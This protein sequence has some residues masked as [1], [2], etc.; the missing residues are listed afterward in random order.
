[1]VLDSKPT[2]IQDPGCEKIRSSASWDHPPTINGGY[3][4]QSTC[5]VAEIACWYDTHFPYRFL[6]TASISFFPLWSRC[7]ISTVVF[8]IINENLGQEEFFALPQNQRS[9]IIHRGS[10]RMW[11]DSPGLVSRVIRCRNRSGESRFLQ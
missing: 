3:G 9:E 8:G 5:A 2:D 6:A 1:M 4:H 11:M 10:F 7:I